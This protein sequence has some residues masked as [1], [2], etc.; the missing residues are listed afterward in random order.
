MPAVK[1]LNTESY[2]VNSDLMLT[3]FQSFVK[4]HSFTIHVIGQ[5]TSLQWLAGLKSLSELRELII[6]IESECSPSPAGLLCWLVEHRLATVEMDFNFP[7]NTA[8]DLHS[9]TDGMVDYL[10]K[11]VLRSNQITRLCLTNV[12]RETM[13]GVHSILVHCPSLVSLEL[14]RTRL[15]YDGILHIICSALKKTHH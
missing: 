2:V 10:L 9:P 8:Y 3:L 1:T 6:S 4:L 7:S 5:P 11:S 14:K 12:S 15:G 13:A